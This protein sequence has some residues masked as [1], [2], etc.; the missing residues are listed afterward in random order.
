MSEDF[1]GK[2]INHRRDEFYLATKC[3]CNP[4]DKDKPHIWEVSITSGI[5]NIRNINRFQ[6]G[7]EHFRCFL[8]H[9]EHL[10]SR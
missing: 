4:T 8:R 6:I 9:F 7:L 2:Y 3:G 1:I 5:V 10:H